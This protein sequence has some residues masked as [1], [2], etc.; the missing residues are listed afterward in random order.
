MSLPSACFFSDNCWI[1]L[2]A[3]I[4]DLWFAASAVVH[5]NPISEIQ[6]GVKLVRLTREPA[7]FRS[8]RSCVLV[9]KHM[10]DGALVGPVDATDPARTITLAHL[11]VT[12]ALFWKISLWEIYSVM[13]SKDPAPECLYC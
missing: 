7:A 9:Y 10:V 13:D 11:D 12:T 4:K 6:C 3:L 2:S 5:L 8:K 1:S